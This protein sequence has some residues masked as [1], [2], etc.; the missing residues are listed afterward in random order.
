MFNLIKRIPSILYSYDIIVSLLIIIINRKKN[1]NYCRLSYSE[2]DYDA[3]RV[4]LYYCRAA[5]I[6]FD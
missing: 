2:S 6:T 1:H 5:V 3:V 4:I